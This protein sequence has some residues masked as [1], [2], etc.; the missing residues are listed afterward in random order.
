MSSLEEIRNKQN[1]IKEY[2]NEFDLT[3]YVILESTLNKLIEFLN[4]QKQ[5]IQQLPLFWNYVIINSGW[6]EELM[7]ND[8][9]Y[10]ILENLIDVSISDI[11]RIEK[12][13]SVF[14]NEKANFLKLKITFT[15]KPNKYMKK[16]ELTK[17]VTFNVDEAFYPNFE[18]VNSGVEMSDDYYEEVEGGKSFFDFFQD[19]N[20]FMDED[21]LDEYKELE[22]DI[23]K[24][25][26]FDTLPFAFEYFC[27]INEVEDDDDDYDDDY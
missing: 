8:I 10:E 25:I 2:R 22:I 6:L 5:Y 18:I 12:D 9:D 7:E 23:C 14:K 4:N 11:E 16:L 17:T 13:H 1:Q 20:E 27:Q 15:F 3:Q 19:G 24:Q 21:E 26:I